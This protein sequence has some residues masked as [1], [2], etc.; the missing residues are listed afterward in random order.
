MK[1]FTSSPLHVIAY[2][3][4]N[5]KKKSCFLSNRFCQYKSYIKRQCIHDQYVFFEKRS[6]YPYLLSIH[7]PLSSVYSKFESIH[8]C[9][10]LVILSAN[11]YFWNK[12]TPLSPSSTILACCFSLKKN[13]Y[14]Y[15]ASVG[16]I[17][18]FL[19]ESNESFLCT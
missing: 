8:C 17:D 9:V 5:L 10:Y 19:S 3:H 4:L 14:N 7:R 18:L 15:T 11:N 1:L 16:N 2:S 6:I 12:L 13:S